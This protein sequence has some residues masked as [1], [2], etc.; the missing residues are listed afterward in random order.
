MKGYVYYYWP[1]L[2]TSYGE[3]SSPG[4]ILLKRGGHSGT[5]NLAL[6][7]DCLPVS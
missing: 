5:G 2:E 6:L 4:L 7:E 1:W 3:E